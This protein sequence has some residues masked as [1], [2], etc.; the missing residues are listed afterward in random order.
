M[1][2]KEAQTQTRSDQAPARAGVKLGS[3]DESLRNP[4]FVRRP[5]ALSC[6]IKAGQ[7]RKNEIWG[8][9]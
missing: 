6:V 2:Q 5:T 3:E 1:G 9:S 8:R 4:A 7:Q